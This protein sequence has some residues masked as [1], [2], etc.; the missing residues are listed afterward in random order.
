MQ[1]AFNCKFLGESSR[2][3]LFS[4]TTVDPIESTLVVGKARVHFFC[5]LVYFSRFIYQH[6]Y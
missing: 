1:R 4:L 3:L 5:R 2:Y 6:Y